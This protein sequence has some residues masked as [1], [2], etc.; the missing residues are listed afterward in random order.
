MFPL[1]DYQ[2]IWCGDFEFTA[3]AGERVIPI[4]FCG[5][6]YFTGR[7]ILLWG[8]E[9]R[10]Q[11][12]AP[13]NTGSDSLFVCFTATAEM[14]AFLALGW[15]MPTNILDLYT[16]E[17]TIN[18]GRFK[19]KGVFSL[20]ETCR[21]Y[22]VEGIGADQKS[23]FQG[24]A[25]RGGPFTEE[26]KGILNKYVESDV[27]L[28]LD[29]LPK[30]IP[31]IKHP[32]LALFRSG[33]MKAV[34]KTEFT[35][36][37]IDPQF[38]I[39]KELWSERLP[40]LIEEVDQSYNCYQGLTFKQEL[41]EQY[42][43][44]QGIM[45]PETP[46][47]LLA[48]DRQTFSDMSQIH[49]QLSELHELRKCV[50][51]T[52][53]I[54]LTVGNDFRNRTGLMPFATETCRNAPSGNKFLFNC[55]KWFRFLVKPEPGWAL[56]NLD[57]RAQ[58]VG[59]GAALSGDPELCRMYSDGDPYLKMGQKA[60]K[61]PQDGTKK[62]HPQVR[63]AFKALSLGI[64]FGMTTYGLAVR[65]K[66]SM[67]EASALMRFHR[68]TFTQFWSWIEGQV[69]TGLL[70]GYV[71]TRYG[72]YRH[73][74]DEEIVGAKGEIYI[75]D[76]N[77]RSVQNFFMQS[78]GSHILQI[79]LMKLWDAGIRVC[80][81]VHDSVLVYAPVDEIE[82]QVK[83]ATEIMEEASRIVLHG[84]NIDVENKIVRFPGRLG[85]ESI[86]ASKMW[87]KILRLVPE[88]EP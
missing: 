81:S 41:F 25:I 56:A 7:K 27:V 74:V 73:I 28:L 17:R 72:W 9:L 65:I 84:F 64:I 57:F 16:E 85:D 12:R 24:L 39:L 23:A 8:D 5:I 67:A 86:G 82:E 51:E 2:E 54:K 35:G 34:S 38:P 63:D 21:R 10:E 49:P 22:G 43:A 18:N 36:I 6:E 33:Y 87:E 37:P 47:G 53:D 66:G 76:P 29:L 60:G 78:H 19:G 20:L 79:S 3:K 83:R 71:V 68:Q 11:D 4:N 14:S 15:P 31:F 1:S 70:N 32:K 80:A 44:G 75:K 55:S 58:E 40:L 45:W 46:S 59:I 61:I 52:R 69:S 62:S 30:M 50:S 42:L 88:I 48:T 26:E 77:I 13:F